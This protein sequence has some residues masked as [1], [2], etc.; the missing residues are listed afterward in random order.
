MK[1]HEKVAASRIAINKVAFEREDVV[2]ALFIAILAR[3]NLFMLGPAGCA[4]SMISR[5]FAASIKA[6]SFL[7]IQCDPFLKKDELIGMVDPF[8]FKT[9]LY[10][11]IKQN[12]ATAVDIMNLDE[13]GRTESI[14]PSLYRLLNEHFYTEM[15]INHPCP[16]QIAIAT[17]NSML[18]ASH[19]A[20]FDRFVFFFF[21]EAMTDENDHLLLE[22]ENPLVLSDDEKLTIQEILLERNKISSVVIPDAIRTTWKN[23]NASLRPEGII[24]SDRAKRWS[25]RVMKASALCEG[26]MEVTDD[27]LWVLRN[28]YSR[29]DKQI[30]IVKKI[31]RQHVNKELDAICCMYDDYKNVYNEWKNAG[32]INSRLFEGQGKEILESM[33]KISPKSINKSEYDRYMK[34]MR[35]LQQELN[36]ASL[37]E[38]RQVSVVKDWKN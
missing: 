16:L 20:L 29:N 21:T 37:N 38:M 27:D 32:K 14:L 18:P 31:M 34:D 26:R 3:M 11:R 33:K 28:V 35:M 19:A 30:S 8:K 17:S 22:D 5:L 10:E 4:K 24:V 12:L 6:A 13:I 25:G 15:G 1:F 7:D 36:I 2:H 9:G 23:I